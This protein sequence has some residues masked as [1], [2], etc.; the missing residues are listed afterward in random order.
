MDRNKNTNINQH[1]ILGWDQYGNCRIVS[2][3]TDHIERD[4]Y[5]KPSLITY[6]DENGIAVAYLD[7]DTC[8]FV[9]AHTNGPSATATNR[10]KDIY[11][12]DIPDAFRDADWDF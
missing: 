11:R 5:G 6:F 4:E 3:A 12:N 10:A 2:Y 8:Y 9:F 7:L 1:R